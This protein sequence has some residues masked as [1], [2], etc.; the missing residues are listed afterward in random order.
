MSDKFTIINLLNKLAVEQKLTWRIKS[1]Y[2]NGEDKNLL[3][4]LI[5][6]MPDQRHRGKI[7][8]QADSGQVQKLQY[9]GFSNSIAVNI[10]D[11][12]LDVINFEKQRKAV[13]STQKTLC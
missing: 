8:F 11:M 1:V 13:R 7:T 3:E 9:K 6:T 12:L 2:A 5:M 10:V 4:I